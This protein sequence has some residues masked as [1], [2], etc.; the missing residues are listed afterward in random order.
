MVCRLDIITMFTV[1]QEIITSK[2]TLAL[3]LS[4][5]TDA[6]HK[7]LHTIL[8]AQPM[9]ATRETTRSLQ[10]E[11]R[12]LVDQGRDLVPS[13]LT[14][15]STDPARMRRISKSSSSLVELH[16][17]AIVEEE[18]ELEGRRPRSKTE[19]AARFSKT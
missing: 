11:E 6:E 19:P 7:P 14:S 8:Y 12:Q 15:F 18:S 9:R 17:E 2:D 5:T 3:P 10:R 16:L 4:L 13:R 1:Q